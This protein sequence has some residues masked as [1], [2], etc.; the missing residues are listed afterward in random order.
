MIGDKRRRMGRKGRTKTRNGE[1]GKVIWD[2]RK[3]RWEGKGRKKR[4]KG[5]G[6]GDRGTLYSEAKSEIRE[7]LTEPFRLHVEHRLGK[8]ITRE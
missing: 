7:I 2:K 6:K 5:E 4:R 8:R 1:K 3:R